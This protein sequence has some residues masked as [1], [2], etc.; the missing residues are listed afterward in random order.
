MEDTCSILPQR[1]PQKNKK[2]AEVIAENLVDFLKDKIIDQ[3]LQAIG[4][5]ST[6]VNTGWEG[7]AMHWVEVKLGRELN[8]LVCALHTNELPL[9]HLITTVDGKTLSNNKW[10]GNICKMLDSSTELKINTS[11]LKITVGEPLITLID[12]IVKDLST[13]QAYGY[14]ITQAIRA[15]ELPKDLALLE[16]GPVSHSRWL[17]TAN[18]LCRMWV[19]KHAWLQRTKPEQFQAHSG[20]HCWRVLPMLV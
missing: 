12:D 5:D 3:S 6:N 8:W 15:G 11:F 14:R 7:G 17:T 18:R 19:S 20:I 16:I 9:R 13:D 4:G 10:T 2:H 1:K